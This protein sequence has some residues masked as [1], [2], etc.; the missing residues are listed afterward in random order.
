MN[1]N[2][3]IFL[4]GASGGIGSAI[5]LKFL[6]AKYSLVLTSSSSEKLQ[7]LREKYGSSHHYYLLDLSNSTDFIPQTKSLNSL[8]FIK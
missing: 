1:I 6:S 5:C 8:F 2:K 4:T 3:K 7:S